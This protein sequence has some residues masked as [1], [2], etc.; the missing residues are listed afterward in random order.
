MINN[1][2]TFKELKEKYNWNY[3][4]AKISEQIN[5]AKKCGIII[6]PQFK[7]GA[8]YF[9]IIKDEYILQNEIWKQHLKFKQIAVSNLGRVRNLNNNHLLG[10]VDKNGYTAIT[11]NS[12]RYFVH[13]LVKETFDPI[14][15][16]D[17]YVIDHI[18]GI[19]TDNR[20]TN[21][22][23]C[24]QKENMEFKKEN[25]NNINNLVAILIQKY[26]YNETMEKLQQ[27]ISLG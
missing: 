24:W 27:L 3:S 9:S 19:R 11:L 23:W 22:R 12:R 6:E 18:N 8:T 7:K 2:Y 5:Y 25:Q 13:K 4:S 17:N 10:Y 20:L 16:A 26:G 14:D 1:C 15:N 21:L